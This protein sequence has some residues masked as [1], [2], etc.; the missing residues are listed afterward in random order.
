VS[1]GPEQRAHERKEFELP[2]QVGDARNRVLGT[3]RFDTRDLSV[4]GAFLRSDLLFEVG[5]VLELEFQ[6]PGGPQVKASGK[7]VHVAR[8]AALDG[9]SAAGMGIAFSN[10]SERDREA[11]RAFLA[12]G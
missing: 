6:V 9:A 12:R 8:E 2:V 5:E 11:V 4:G 10:L 3:I 7:V 1:G